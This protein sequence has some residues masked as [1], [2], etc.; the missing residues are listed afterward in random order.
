MTS[1]GLAVE[2]L[3]VRYGGLVAVDDVSLEAPAGRITGLIGPNGAGKTSIFNACSG[4]LRPSSGRVLLDGHDVTRLS[5]PRRTQRGLGRAETRR[6]AG[7][8]VGGHAAG[9]GHVWLRCDPMLARPRFDRPR[10]P[11]TRAIAP[12]RRLLRLQRTKLRRVAARPRGAHRV[13]PAGQIFVIGDS[14]IGLSDGSEAPIL[15]WLDRLAALRPRALFLNGDLFHYLIAD[16]KFYTSSVE[17]VF[18]RF[19]ELRDSG[20]AIH[21]VE[22]NRDFFLHGSFV[23]NG[24]TD[25]A[26]EYA[27]AAGDKKYLIIHGD[28]INDRDIPYRDVRRGG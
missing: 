4:L 15:A 20:V 23:E 1:S 2:S 13:I 27:V 3:S 6:G 7:H 16:P 22:G 8:R 17:K 24:V 5:L 26:M 10:F 9:A 21:Y 12:A 14:H 11:A 28:M 25:I 19:R 18:A